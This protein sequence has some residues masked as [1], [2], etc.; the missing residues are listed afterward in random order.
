MVLVKPIL[1]GYDRVV[2]NGF[3]MDEQNQMKKFC[4]TLV[5]T[6]LL[7]SLS[8][9]ATVCGSGI[10]VKQLELARLDEMIQS[11]D[12]RAMLVV[13]AAWCGPCRKE[14][15]TLV[16]LYDKYKDQ[17]LKIVGISVDVNGPQAMQPIVDKAKVNFP[18]YWV[19]ESAVKKYN[20]SGIPLILLV[21]DGEIIEKI[22][23]NRPEKYLDKKIKTLLKN[24]G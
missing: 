8:Y 16:K 7:F 19:G 4:F 11:Q 24:T 12:Q 23:G 3:L 15:P 9:P 13:M 20:V 17:G 22:M 18:V 6:I 1:N 10:V 2:F 21:R 5:S 14:L